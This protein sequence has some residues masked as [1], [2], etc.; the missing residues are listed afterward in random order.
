[1]LLKLL[2]FLLCQ[3]QVWLEMWKFCFGFCMHKIKSFDWVGFMAEW[4][5]LF[6]WF[7]CLVFSGRGGINRKVGG[8][9]RQS[10]YRNSGHED[11]PTCG[12]YRKPVYFREAIES[13]RTGGEILGLW[14]EHGFGYT[15]R[16]LWELVW[17][18]WL[19]KRSSSEVG[20]SNRWAQ[21][22]GK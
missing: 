3:E 13:K 18:V 8:T 5:H 22:Q 4:S 21:L 11:E 15:E 6:T 1:M 20:N 2:V 14:M 7:V 10:R 9:W 12:L 16:R 17:G 19:L